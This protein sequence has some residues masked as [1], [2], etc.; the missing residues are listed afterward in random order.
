MQ[1]QHEGRAWVQ[2]HR[3]GRRAVAPRPAWP[4]HGGTGGA[5]EQADWM[6]DTHSI[7]WNGVC[8]PSR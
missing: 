8:E 2:Q 4:K 6:G 3:S 7:V 5:P 1:Q